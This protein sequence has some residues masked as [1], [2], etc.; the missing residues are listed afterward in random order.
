[1][2]G[3]MQALTPILCIA[4]ATGAVYLLYLAQPY[5][6]FAVSILGY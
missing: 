3:T 2:Q 4:V 1:M 6:K 5:F